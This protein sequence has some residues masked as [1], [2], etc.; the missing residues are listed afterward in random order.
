LG[1][2]TDVD[3][4]KLERG[5]ILQTCSGRNLGPLTT[6]D[7]YLEGYIIGADMVRIEIDDE[8]L[9]FYVLAYLQSEMGQQILKRG[10]TGSVIDHLS[11]KHIGAQEIPLLSE[12]TQRKVVSA[13]KYAFEL[14]EEARLTLD[15]LST[16][17]ENSLPRPERIQHLKNGWSMQSHELTDRLDAAFYDR[18]V[19]RVRQELLALGG[20]ALK[21]VATVLKP[22]GRYKTVYVSSEYGRPIVSGTQLLQEYPVNLKYIA[23]RAFDENISDYELHPTWTAYQADGRVERGLGTPAFVTSERDGWLASGHIG[24]LVAKPGINPGWLYIAANIWHT[25]IQIKSRASGSVV[26]STFPEDMEDII[27]P[28]YNDSGG[29]LVCKMWEQFVV[30]KDSEKEAIAAFEDEVNKLTGAG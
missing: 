26:D 21:D 23:P 6:V 18:L 16:E 22:K 15:K 13:M 10:K 19:A 20:L 17:Y 30:A 8:N 9:R 29:D 25:Q 4:Y 27:L 7:S 2:S 12:E 1:R 5:T 11:P 14:R 28:P 24:R 3:T